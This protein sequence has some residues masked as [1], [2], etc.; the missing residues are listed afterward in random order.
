MSF[1]EWNDELFKTHLNASSL[2][3]MATHNTGFSF[4]FIYFLW[5]IVFIFAI[6]VRQEFQLDHIDATTKWFSSL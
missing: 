3:L 1:F 6:Q 2:V 4:L 5:S